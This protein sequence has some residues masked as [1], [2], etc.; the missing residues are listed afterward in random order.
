MAEH[1]PQQNAEARNAQEVTPLRRSAVKDL[2]LIIVMPKWGGAENASPRG[3]FDKSEGIA[4]IGNW[5]ED[6]QIQVC[7]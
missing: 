1:V 5:T 4:R 3:V 7:A 6:D 2:S